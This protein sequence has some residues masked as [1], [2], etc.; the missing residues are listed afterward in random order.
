MGS[1]YRQF[2]FRKQP[3]NEAPADLIPD[4]GKAERFVQTS[5]REWAYARAYNTSE[6]RAAEL[7]IWLHRYKWH[8][9][10]ASIGSKPPISRLSLPSDNLLRLNS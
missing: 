9:P 3:D 6:E 7:P 2:P 5:L 1:P 10:H 4:N 8:R